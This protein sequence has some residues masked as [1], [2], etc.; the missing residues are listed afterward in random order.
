MPLKIIWKFQQPSDDCIS[1]FKHAVS[2]R[3]R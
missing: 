2:V 1:L 3:C